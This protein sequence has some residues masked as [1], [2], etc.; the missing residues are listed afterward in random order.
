MIEPENV[1]VG[2]K[3]EVRIQMQNKSRK[4]RTVHATVR[5]GTLHY[6]G[7]IKR[8][9]VTKQFDVTLTSARGKITLKKLRKMIM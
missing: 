4:T 5:L 3:V 1:L 7:V 2:Q 9:L 6:T 8:W